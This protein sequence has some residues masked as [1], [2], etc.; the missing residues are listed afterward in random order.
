MFTVDTTGNKNMRGTCARRIVPDSLQQSPAWEASASECKHRGWP[1]AS[2]TP[3]CSRHEQQAAPP[4][5]QLRQDP[6]HSRGTPVAAAE[7]AGP[8]RAPGQLLHGP[9]HR[10]EI[11]NNLSNNFLEL[12]EK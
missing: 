3:E 2:G 4:Q 9:G 8:P 1:C 12:A 11:T 5:V 7:A 6:L 10:M